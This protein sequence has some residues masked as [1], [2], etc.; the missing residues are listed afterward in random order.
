MKDIDVAQARL[1]MALGRIEQ[2]ALNRPAGAAG[3]EIVV[4]EVVVP[5][6]AAAAEIA[7]LE[8]ENA[9]LAKALKAL[10]TKHK[11]LK[12]K[13]SKAIERLDKTIERVDDLFA[14]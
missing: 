7:R 10:E 5:D 2:A 9:R 8:A 4:R 12:D 14:R 3:T 1:E 11:S 6:P 13:S